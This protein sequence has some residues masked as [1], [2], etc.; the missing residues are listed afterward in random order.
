M[1]TIYALVPVIADVIA[2]HCPGTS[3]RAYF[4]RACLREDWNEVKNM[5]EAM[6]AEPWHLRGRQEHRL[7]EFLELLPAGHAED[8]AF[9]QALSLIS[10]PGLGRG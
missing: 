9:L 6:L 2:A 3:T 4:V 1:P 5:V 8:R 10:R 7:R